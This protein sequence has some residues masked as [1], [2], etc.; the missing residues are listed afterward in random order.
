MKEKR[1]WYLAKWLALPGLVYI[2]MQAQ[3]MDMQRANDITQMQWMMNDKAQQTD[4]VFREI[5]NKLDE[6]YRM[7][8]GMHHEIDMIRRDMDERLEHG[9]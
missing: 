6:A 3:V 9:E 1:I 4:F 2:F 8:D 7:I 5:N